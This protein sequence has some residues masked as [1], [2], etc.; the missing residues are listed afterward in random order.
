M[1]N[2]DKI[3]SKERNEEFVASM[4][5]NTYMEPVA[6]GD[7]GFIW[8]ADLAVDPRFQQK[9]I[10]KRLLA[11]GFER[12]DAENLPI[13]Q[14]ASAEGN[15]L[16][17]QVGF[18]EVGVYEVADV[19]GIGFIRWPKGKRPQAKAEEAPPS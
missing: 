4:R 12:A 11:W 18:E 7:N 5:T 19:R 16:Y 2:L 9:G 3:S 13:G 10:G 15:R 14:W 17:R 6:K 8:L 1:F